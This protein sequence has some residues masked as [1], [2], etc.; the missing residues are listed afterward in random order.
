[1]LTEVN[2]GVDGVVGDELPGSSR[3]SSYVYGK[4]K[5][6]L[7]AASKGFFR[8]DYS[9]SSKAYSDLDN[10][11]SLHY[12]NV[13]SIDAQLGMHLGNFEFLLFGR[14]LAD[15]RNRVNAFVLVGAP[16]QVLQ[17]PLTV[18]LTVRWNY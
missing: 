8:V 18:G 5:F 13:G 1:R 7:G 14:N 17:T 11:T 2:T 9:Y 16:A 3:F 6:N 10:A 12:G 4:Y 15:A